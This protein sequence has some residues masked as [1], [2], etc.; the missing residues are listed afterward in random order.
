LLQPD[1]V[2]HHKVQ[3][4]EAD[5]VRPRMRAGWI[6]DDIAPVVLQAKFDQAGF[7]TQAF[8]QP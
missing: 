4:F 7:Q 3:L 1:G 2:L 8:R 5:L 6:A